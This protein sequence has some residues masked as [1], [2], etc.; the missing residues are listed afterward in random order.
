MISVQIFHNKTYVV[1]E[2]PGDL[3][4]V[5]EAL[6]IIFYKGNGKNRKYDKTVNLWNQSE[7]SF[8]SGYL[9]T[10]AA[11]LDKHGVEV[12]FEDMR[13]CSITNTISLPKRAFEGLRDNQED[14]R[15]AIQT[16]SVGFASSATATGKSKYIDIAIEDKK[17]L[18]CI[19]VPTEAL[20]DQIYGELCQFYGTLNVSKSLKDHE[21]SLKQKNKLEAMKE[22]KKGFKQINA[23]YVE[24]RPE[25][26]Y[27]ETKG[28]EKIGGKHVKVRKADSVV[29]KKTWPKILV[30]CN[31]SLPMLPYEY[32]QDVEMFISDE[33]HK[34]SEIVRQ[35]LLEAKSCMYRY[36]ISATN[37]RERREDMHTLVSG[38]GNNIIYEE[39]PKDSIEKGK[40][41]KLNH[42]IRNPPTPH[43]F[44]KDISNP[45]DIIK[46]CIT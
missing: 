32:V 37:W 42:V 14:F 27:L 20:R 16:S 5:A 13:N 21:N 22:R 34:F 29:T 30:I 1:S 19:S 2:D 23:E 31:A 44:F 28:Y 33:G 11:K 4:Y 41:K 25:D 38:F 45:D 39:L 36:S 18:T 10:L 40:I 7:K 17:V 9:E 15:L 24:E 46:R 3:G 6:K 43:G 26:L 12:E 35:F 8:P